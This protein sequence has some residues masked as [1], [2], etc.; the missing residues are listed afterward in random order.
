VGSIPN[1]ISDISIVKV[2]GSLD[3]KGEV[4]VTV[5][6][7]TSDKSPFSQL[8]L[9]QPRQIDVSCCAGSTSKAEIER[10]SALQYPGAW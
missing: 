4:V 5:V 6:A 3:S 7:R 1:R 8:G 9:S 10:K 2:S